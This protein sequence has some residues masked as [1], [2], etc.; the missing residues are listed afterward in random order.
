[1][2]DGDMNSKFF[3][4]TTTVGKKRNRIKKLRN[5]DNILVDAHDGLSKV[6]RDYFSN[7]FRCRQGVYTTINKACL[8]ELLGRITKFC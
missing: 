5:K 8:S 4:A 6:A 2:R 1:M 3:H 7:L